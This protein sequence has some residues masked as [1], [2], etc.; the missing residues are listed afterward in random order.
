MRKF[1][2]SE[3]SLVVVLFVAVIVTFTF[4]HNDSKE[5]EDAYIGVNNGAVKGFYLTQN[6][7][8]ENKA[9]FAPVKSVENKK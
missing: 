5:I 3:R 8:K 7:V 4:A 1:L 6:T 2:V 9:T